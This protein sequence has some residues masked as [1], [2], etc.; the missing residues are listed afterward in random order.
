MDDDLRRLGI[1]RDQLARSARRP[2]LMIDS[3]EYWSP[4]EAIRSITEIERHF[5]L[6]TADFVYIRLLGD[7]QKI[8][9]LTLRWDKEVLAHQSRLERWA[10]FLQRLGERQVRV[11]VYVNN[12][13]AGHAPATLRRLQAL[14][15]GSNRS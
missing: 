9:E 14:Y 3:N 10:A 12:H 7:R 15:A 5:D 8:E 6:V 13:Y 11:L 2:E 1:M 4:K